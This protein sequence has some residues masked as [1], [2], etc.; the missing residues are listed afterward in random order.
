MTI[1]TRNTAGIAKCVTEG[2]PSLRWVLQLRGAN[3]RN[4][5]WT[6]GRSVQSVDAVVVDSF[7]LTGGAKL[8]ARLCFVENQASRYSW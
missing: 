6:C 4:A 1:W 3:Q 5:Q 7:A 2:G 8:C